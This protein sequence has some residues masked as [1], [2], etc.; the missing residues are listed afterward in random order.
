LSERDRQ[1]TQ[2]GS[3]CKT[4]QGRPETVP[5]G[6]L[7]QFV[8][9]LVEQGA[10]CHMSPSAQTAYTIRRRAATV[11]A[12]N[13][14]HCNTAY[15]PD[16][17]LPA[18]LGATTDLAMAVHGARLILAVTPAQTTQS[19]L[20]DVARFV[21][22]GATLVLCAKGIDAASSRFLSD[23]ARQA[24]PQAQIV[25]A[26]RPRLCR[27]WAP[28]HFVRAVLVQPDRVIGRVD[29]AVVVV[30]AGQGGG[31]VEP[32][33]VEIDFQIGV[34]EQRVDYVEVDEPNS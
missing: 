9:G 17:A 32:H 14:S 12:I 21:S 13:S 8:L 29:R 24:L 22:P 31:R 7:F 3:I 4:E 27:R 6:S 11:D 16:I 30:V 28:A 20:A 2:F 26:V 1:A 23:V 10:V 18:T 15:L 33:V 5:A 19:V 25:R 34:G